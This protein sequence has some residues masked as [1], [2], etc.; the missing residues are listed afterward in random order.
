[1]LLCSYLIG[2][3]Y[4]ILLVLNLQIDYLG[5]TECSKV[6]GL[7]SVQSTKINHALDL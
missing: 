4:P 6:N 7:G 1:M 3:V 2:E 5:V